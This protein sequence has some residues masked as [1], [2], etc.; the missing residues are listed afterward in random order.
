MQA[1]TSTEWILGGG[2]VPNANDWGLLVLNPNRN[3]DH[4]GVRTGHLAA[5]VNSPIGSIVTA[6]G[7]PCNFNECRV[8]HQTVSVSG[9]ALEHTAIIG[10]DMSAGSSGGPVIIN[11]GKH[12]RIDLTSVPLALPSDSLLAGQRSKLKWRVQYG[13]WDN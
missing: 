5:T 13:S 1:W 12:V 6:V 9:P 8:P 7:Y 10:S 2:S 4:V 3:G 11:F